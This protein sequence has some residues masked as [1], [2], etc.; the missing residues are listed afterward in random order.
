MFHANTHT[1]IYKQAN[2]TNS[3]ISLICNI[4]LLN[5]NAIYTILHYYLM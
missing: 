4:Y 3:E 5:R 1:I 2:I